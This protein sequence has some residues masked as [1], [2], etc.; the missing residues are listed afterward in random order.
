MEKYL[1][2]K[3]IPIPPATKGIRWSWFVLGC[4][5]LAVGCIYL[6]SVDLAGGTLAQSQ[7]DTLAA[8][9][10]TQDIAH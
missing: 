6:T 7:T 2:S 9:E 8:A 4:S 1:L 5:C 10:T 3:T